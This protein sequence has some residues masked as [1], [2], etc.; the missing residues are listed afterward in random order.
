MP[1][2][3]LQHGIA[4]KA[5]S[6]V[7]AIWTD[8]GAAVDEIQHDYGEDLL[9]QTSF[10]EEVTWTPVVPLPVRWLIRGERVGW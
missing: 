6:A 8:I 3:T 10:D 4:D 1:R 7:S 9:V 2:R 5:V